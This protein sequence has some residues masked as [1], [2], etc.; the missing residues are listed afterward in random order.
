[1]EPAVYFMDARSDS[2]DTS[3]IAKTVTVFDAAGLDK[4]ISPGDVVAIKVHCGE[5][6]SSA[7]LRPVYARAIADRVK[8][9]GGRPFVCDTTTL[10][11]GPFASRANELDLL[12][13]A[14][15]NGF[16]SAT[17]GCPFICADGYIGTSDYRVDIPEGY[18][19][20]EAYVAQAIAAA[21]VLITLSHFKGHGMGV[22]GG[23]IKNLGIGA[24]SKRG[25]F[26]V[27]MGR[28]PRYGIG[29][30]VNF[31]PDAFAGKDRDPEW[32][33][34]EDCCPHGLFKIT[35]DEKIAWDKENCIGCL[36]CLGVMNPRGIFEPSQDLFDATDIAI[37][38]AALAVT[39][40]VPKVGFINLAIDV[41][42]KCDCAGFSDVPIVPHLGV[43][44]STD[45]VAID[46]ACVD[47]ARHAPG[48]PGSLSEEMGVD[49]PGDRKF[50]LAGAA[51]E[52]LSEQTTINT[53]VVIGLGS[54]KYT[55]V[56]VSPAG[57]DKFRFPLDPRPT[58]L[59]YQRLFEKFQPFPVDRHGGLG[60][61]RLEEVDMEAVRLHDGPKVSAD[62]HSPYHGDGTHIPVVEP[63]IREAWHPGEEVVRHLN[64]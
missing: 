14:A 52:G 34:I 38:D 17:L 59:R 33:I 22:I 41:S 40:T 61:D 54:R 53:G 57:N 32:N 11:Y 49:A 21:D 51:I 23:A 46:Q 18:L 62:S 48:I 4:L 8:E 15:R 6:N 30:V 20:K 28:H 7:Y 26:N 19:L 36:G 12:E 10:T 56:D 58:R 42:P 31:N 60:Y 9:A 37:A 25:K 64:D 5:W 16:T 45:P 63:V 47:K 13:T 29:N 3:L 27:H 24:Q 44:A 2:A 1:M 35:D 50:D 39:K 43:F 55:M